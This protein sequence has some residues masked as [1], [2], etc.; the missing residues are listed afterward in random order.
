MP[1]TKDKYSIND[2]IYYYTIYFNNLADHTKFK[3]IMIIKKPR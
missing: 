2:I 3:L 1:K